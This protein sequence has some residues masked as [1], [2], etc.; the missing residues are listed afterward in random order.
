[1][2]NT[3][4]KRLNLEDSVPVKNIAGWNV[5][6]NRVTEMGRSF[7]FAPG[8]TIMMKR[9]EIMQHVQN[10]LK[11]FVGVDGNGSHAT[12]YIDDDATRKLCGFESGDGKKKQNVL[13][14]DVVKELFATKS[15][16][17][18]EKKFAE[19][20]VTRAEMGAIIESIKRLGL[21]DYAKIRY[22]EEYTGFRV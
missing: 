3:E 2:A 12:L 17:S 1:M 18:F 7:D 6:F 9:Q 14:D 13:T 21:N 10:G 11:L 8:A 20:V 16:V 5:A 22:I 15:Q 4:E 19:T